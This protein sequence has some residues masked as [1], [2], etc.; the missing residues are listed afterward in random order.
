MKNSLFTLALLFAICT[1]VLRAQIDSS[2][3]TGFDNAAEQAG[4]EQFRTGPAAD[5]F[6]QWEF[7]S[8]NAYSAPNSLIHYYPV[9]GSDTT[10]DWYV[11][12]PM[13]FKTGGAIDSL[14]FEFTGFGIPQASDTVAIYLLVG[15]KDPEAASEKILLVDFRDSLY[16]ANNGWNSI[17]DIDIPAQEDTCYVG[18]KY[19]TVANW[20]DV[21]FDNLA[22][23]QTLSDTNDTLPPTGVGEYARLETHVLCN[24]AK[25]FITFCSPTPPEN[26]STLF[27]YDVQG[28]LVLKQQVIGNRPVP[29]PFKGGVYYYR[30]LG[31]KGKQTGSGKLVVYQGII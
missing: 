5:P 17:R 6:Y 2:Y 4:W 25:G 16:M 26:N 12:P 15:S 1:N 29:V 8:V 23:T 18:F 14:R 24:P 3:F 21:K 27:I 13:S 9:G 10:I 19:R 30:V 7:G 28:R 31:P 11:G 22:I 20:L